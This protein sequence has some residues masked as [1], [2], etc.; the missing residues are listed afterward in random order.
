VCESIEH[1]ADGCYDTGHGA[2]CV[3]KAIKSRDGPDSASVTAAQSKCDGVSGKCRVCTPTHRGVYTCE[4]DFCAV[5]P[6]DWCRSGWSCHDDCDCCKKDRKRGAK[7]LERSIDNLEVS[8]VRKCEPVEPAQVLDSP[9][10]SCPKEFWGY[11]SCRDNNSVI[12]VCDPA[13]SNW[14][15][16]G[17]CVG[18]DHCCES[19]RD[20]PYAAQCKC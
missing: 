12:V 4:Y 19:R 20:N 16:V 2:L 14:R 9:Y 7:T 13:D 18:G 6:G 1:C 15:A 17:K 5:K 3:D 8:P 10:G 11:Q